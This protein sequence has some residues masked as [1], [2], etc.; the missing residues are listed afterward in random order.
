[1]SNTNTTHISL[2]TAKLLKDCKINSEST[3][4]IQ[5]SLNYY[6][7]IGKKSCGLGDKVLR[8][9]GMDV[10]YPA[11]TWQEILWEFPAEFFGVTTEEEMEKW[12]NKYID[13][14]STGESFRNPYRC[15]EKD[16]SKD[17]HYCICPECQYNSINFDRQYHICTKHILKLLQQKKYDEADLYFRKKCILVNSK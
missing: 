15:E 4:Q 6:Q 17:Y 13:C 10:E 16:A 2:E 12:E 14:L 7:T 3:Y 8:E 5:H 1:M 11:Y 9:C